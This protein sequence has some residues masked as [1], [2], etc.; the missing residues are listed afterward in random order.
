M[1]ICEV[2]GTVTLSRSHSSLRGAVWRVAAPLNREALSG[3]RGGR[4]EPYVVYDELGA[5]LG[6]LIA[7]SEGAEASAPFHPEQKPIDAYN[8]AILDHCAIRHR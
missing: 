6:C 4:G 8:S 2:I 7:V 3:D 5:G 1:R